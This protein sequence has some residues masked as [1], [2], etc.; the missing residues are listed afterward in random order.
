M[1][2]API[3]SVFNLVEVK[4][5]HNRTGEGVTAMHCHDNRPCVGGG[6]Q[7]GDGLQQAKGQTPLLNLALF[8]SHQFFSHGLLQGQG[9]LTGRRARPARVRFRGENLGNKNNILSRF[10]IK[11]NE[12]ISAFNDFWNQHLKHLNVNDP[13]IN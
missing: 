12:N 3:G 6:E 11:Y 8:G 7:G 4:L 1:L 10:K 5:T 2:F 13:I 9:Q